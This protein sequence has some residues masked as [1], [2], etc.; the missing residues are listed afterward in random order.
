M[1]VHDLRR[2][3]NCTGLY[4]FLISSRLRAISKIYAARPI[5]R[6]VTGRCAHPGEIRHA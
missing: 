4:E 5:F 6:T 3:K 2:Q 1:A